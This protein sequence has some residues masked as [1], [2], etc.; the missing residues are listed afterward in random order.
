MKKSEKIE[1]TREGTTSE[2]DSY[3]Q[4]GTDQKPQQTALTSTQVSIFCLFIALK[5]RLAKVQRAI[6]SFTVGE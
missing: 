3:A 4:A 6:R 5:N 2:S 1:E